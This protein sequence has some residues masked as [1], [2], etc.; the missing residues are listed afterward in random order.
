MMSS[1]AAARADL[2]FL[3]WNDCSPEE[4]R[5]VEKILGKNPIHSSEENRVINGHNEDSTA[6]FDGF[7]PPPPIPFTVMRPT[8][9]DYPVSGPQ[10][11]AASMQQP[12]AL[13]TPAA[14]MQPQALQQPQQPLSAASM[15]QPQALSAPAAPMQ[16][17]ALSAPAAPMQ[18]QQPLSAAAS[19]YPP[20]SNMYIHNTNVTANVNVTPV[21]AAAELMTKPP[22]TFL[23]NSEF[24]PPN[25]QPPPTGILATPTSAPSN[26]IAVPLYPHPYLV[27]LQPPLPPGGPGAPGRPDAANT[28]YLMGPLGPPP[29]IQPQ[30]HPHVIQAPHQPPPPA[31]EQQ[32]TIDDNASP[33]IPIE[34]PT[35]SSECPKVL[36]EVPE[37]EEEEPPV[38]ENAAQENC[39]NETDNE[40]PSEEENAS[41]KTKTWASLLFNSNSNSSGSSNF[42]ISDG[43]ARPT[44]KISPFT[45]CA[46]ETCTAPSDGSV[47]PLSESSN[48]SDLAK[49]FSSYTLN[50]KSPSVRPR[51]LCNR[52][53]WCFVNAILQALLS[54]PPFFNVMR[55][56][57][58]P[59]IDPPDT[60][61]VI[62]RAVWDFVHQSEVMTSFPK[63]YRKEK[64]KKAE[65][66]PLGKPCEATTILNMLLSLQSHNF[67]VVEGRQED[68]EEFLTFLLNGLNDEV[69]ALLKLTQ[70]ASTDVKS[71]SDGEEEDEWKEVGPKNK[72]CVTRRQATSDTIIGTMFEGQIRSCLQLSS[73]E[74]TA[75]LQPFFTLQLDIQSPSVRSVSDALAAYFTDEVIHGYMCNTT[76]REVDASRSLSL[77]ALPPILILHLK[78]FIYDESRCQKLLKAIDFPVDLDIANN[79][80]SSGSRT[81]YN[82]K[83]RQYKLFSVVYHNGCEAT[84]GHYVADVYHT[85]LSTWLR[86]DDSNVKTV[87]EITVR[88]HDK[89]SVAYILFYRRCDTMIGNERAAAAATKQ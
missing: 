29:H 43:N 62:L 74:P 58:L 77:E 84:K 14:P 86:C 42:P 47:S 65:D 26:F 8:R 80:L 35:L 15:Q 70:E 19:M 66:L 24:V 7:P 25:A 30:P 41:Q 34:E 50:H 10:P 3:D 85:G 17:Q 59:P 61:L 21:S 27:P 38:V 37:V 60:A 88:A 57:P 72:S 36:E 45:D 4:R 87:S 2:D 12:Q 71:V 33:P 68:A 16:P 11:Q 1:D 54:C 22:L 18:P 49:F 20:P 13:S 53:N 82:N 75:T 6:M 32:E 44:A 78:R 81:K 39:P 89:N 73:G 46:K 64:N 5:R 48:G 28:Q 69:L 67:K 51:G 63:L 9:F 83:Q 40:K 31:P 23:A 52:S 55:T 79:I 56:L 76:K